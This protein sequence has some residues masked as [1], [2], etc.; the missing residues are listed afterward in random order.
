MECQTKKMGECILLPKAATFREV[1][2]DLIDKPSNSKDFKSA[3]KFVSRCLE[4]LEKDEFDLEENCC[5]NKYHVMGAGPDKTLEVR[6]AL[7]DYFIEIRYSLKGRLPQHIV[8]SKG[9]QLYEE[10]C[11]LKTDAGKEPDKLKITRKWLQEW[12]KDYRFSLKYPNKQFSL[13]QEV[14]KRRII[15]FLKNV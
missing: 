5:K 4:K 14:R 8:L 12:C 7:F 9:R 11:I 6:H 2:K 1:F 13:T 10:Y 3:T 15:Q